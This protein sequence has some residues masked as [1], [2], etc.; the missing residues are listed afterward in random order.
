M[1]FTEKE[2]QEADVV[3]RSRLRTLFWR[4]G[5]HYRCQTFDDLAQE[6][7]LVMLDRKCLTRPFIFTVAKLVVAR[8][9]ERRERKKEKSYHVPDVDGKFWVENMVGKPTEA[10]DPGNA[11]SLIALI[12]KPNLRRTAEAIVTTNTFADARRS[13]GITKTTMQ[14]HRSLL[15]DC[16]PAPV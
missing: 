3:L 8:F 14:R 7:W 10:K 6:C 11:D 2:I 16:L 15:R 13:I 4:N 12:D 5:I 9:I 1:P